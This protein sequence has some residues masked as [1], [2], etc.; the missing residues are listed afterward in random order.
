MGQGINF[1]SRRDPCKTKAA[2]ADERYQVFY[3]EQILGV[4]ALSYEA[5]ARTGRPFRHTPVTPSPAVARSRDIFHQL[6][7]DPRN[8]TTNPAMLSTFVTEMG[9]IKGR[10]QTML[11]VKN[12]RL[13]GRTIRRA[14][15]MGVIPN[16]SKF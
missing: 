6:N 8:F 15:M 12:Q 3:P 2:Q 7:L 9:K 13:L 10:E 16:L 14:K 4:N 11:T 5:C 1:Y